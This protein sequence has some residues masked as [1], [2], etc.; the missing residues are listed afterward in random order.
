MPRKFSLPPRVSDPDMHRGTCVTLVPSCMPGSLTSG[1][2]WSLWWGKRSRHSRRMCNPQ[3]YVSGKRPIES[4]LFCIH[5]L[6]PRDGIWQQISGSTL[7]GVMGC[8]LTE[9]DHYMNQCWLTTSKVQWH[10]QPHRM[11][12]GQHLNPKMDIHSHSSKGSFTRDNSAIN[13]ENWLK[14]IHPKRYPRGP[15]VKLSMS[16]EGWW[17]YI[18]ICRHMYFI[19]THKCI[20]KYTVKPLI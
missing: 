17:L 4:R 9:P 19:H 3:L 2:L 20:Y 1:F 5:S 14:F 15:C 12:H 18:Y 11:G 10:C 8:C 13:H 7:A 16:L 6:W